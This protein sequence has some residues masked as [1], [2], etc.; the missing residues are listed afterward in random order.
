MAFCKTYLLSVC[1]LAVIGLI[2]AHAQRIV[3]KTE[4]GD[5]FLQLDSAKASITVGNFLR[6]ADQHLYD[7]VSFYRVVRMN[8][9]PDKIIKIEVIQGGLD[10]DS[11][12]RMDSIKQE[13]TQL[14]GLKHLNGTISMARTGP[15]SASSEFFICINDQPEL[16]FGGRRNPDG[17]GFAAFGTVT[18]G[19]EVVRKIQSGETGIAEKGQLLL[20]PVK[21]ITI[22]RLV[23]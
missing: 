11:S 13:T 12:K 7:G 5:I 20:R 16:D 17:Q 14:T 22:S 18:D 23:P 1:C 9:Q 8:N 21:I 15:N 10:K 6:Y 4:V 2:P 19:M 3:I